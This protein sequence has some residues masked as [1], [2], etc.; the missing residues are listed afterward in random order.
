MGEWE[1]FALNFQLLFLVEL[2]LGMNRKMSWEEAKEAWKEESEVPLDSS[3]EKNCCRGPTPNR[4]AQPSKEPES[5]DTCSTCYRLQI[6]PYFYVIIETE[7]ALGILAPDSLGVNSS[8]R[9]MVWLVTYHSKQKWNYLF[10]L[11]WQR[12]GQGELIIYW[13]GSIKHSTSDGSQGLWKL[14]LWDGSLQPN[15]HETC[16][17]A[18]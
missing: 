1:L 17:S 8:C 9:I 7:G 6:M 5:A 14:Y 2:N 11:S 3:K 4:P 12:S 13:L 16:I 15:W 18:R 10:F